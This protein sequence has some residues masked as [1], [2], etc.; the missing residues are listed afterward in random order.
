MAAGDRIMTKMDPML[1]L[2]GISVQFPN[3]DK[4]IFGYAGISCPGFP[5]L[6]SVFNLGG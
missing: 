2:K 4:L 5:P 1:G 6:L 3:P